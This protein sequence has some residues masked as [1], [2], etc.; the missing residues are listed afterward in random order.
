MNLKREMVVGAALIVTALFS[1]SMTGVWRIE[2]ARE[3]VDQNSARLN[4]LQEM[5]V[6]RDAL[7]KRVGLDDENGLVAISL[8]EHVQRTLKA[9][10]LKDS[11]LRGLHPREEE[12]LGESGAVRE[13]HQIDITG[14]T[15]AQMGAWLACWD[16]PVQPW[17]VVSMDWRHVRA[18][19]ATN[20]N[21]YDCT[22]VCQAVLTK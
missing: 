8:V 21:R 6:Q 4:S 20:P 7:Q 18:Q 17:T 9:A 10:G 19:T 11:V 12:K 14:V 1:W 2:A 5:I 15:P 3:Q 16:N 13:V 22:L